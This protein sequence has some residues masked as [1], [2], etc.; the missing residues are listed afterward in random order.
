VCSVSHLFT[1]QSFPSTRHPPCKSVPIT[2]FQIMDLPPPPFVAPSNPTLKS[3]KSSTH[4]PHSH[5]NSRAS[6]SSKRPSH[7]QSNSNSSSKTKENGNA[8][9]KTKASPG[10]G[11]GLANLAVPPSTTTD[12]PTQP[13]TVRYARL[14]DFPDLVWVPT[15]PL[16]WAAA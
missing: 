12:P 15:A 16:S 11:S 7:T 5:P 13:Q 14:S 4:Q 6:P 8:K 3:S 1:D 10:S 9:G 2:S